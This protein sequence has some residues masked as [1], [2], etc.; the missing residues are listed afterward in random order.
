M[1]SLF[2]STT[3]EKQQDSCSTAHEKELKIA[4]AW[5]YS[6]KL[7]TPAKK[8]IPHQVLFLSKNSHHNKGMQVNAFAQHP[9]VVA[10]H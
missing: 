7:R 4:L 5:K 2:K 3:S 8:V 10:T 9:E 6:V 1:L